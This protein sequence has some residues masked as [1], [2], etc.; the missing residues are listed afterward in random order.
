MTMKMMAN[1][2]RG[3]EVPGDEGRGHRPTFGERAAVPTHRAAH[4]NDA[5]SPMVLRP[6]RTVEIAVMRADS[7][8]PR[9]MMPE[10]GADS[11]FLLLPG[12]GE[13][14]ELMS[15][16]AMVFGRGGGGAEWKADALILRLPRSAAQIHASARHGGA[17]RLA[18]RPLS[19]DLIAGSPLRQM[20]AELVQG[21]A[22]EE[23]C[24][25]ILAEIVTALVA[26]HGADTAF[27]L[28]RSITFARAHL[29]KHATEPLALEELASKAGVTGITLQRGFK[30]CFGMTVASYS[31][32]VRLHGAR[33]RLQC[34]WESR[35]IAGIAHGA[36]FP[37]VTTFVRAYQKLFGE[38]PTQTRNAA[39][40]LNRIDHR[41]ST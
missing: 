31:Q 13:P 7:A 12:N 30:A 34:G 25:T 17:R 20:L 18:L 14:V 39:S 40:R 23:R 5:A 15:R 27:P 22:G 28:S 33:A 24:G 9:G 32:A 11:F 19:I 2:S 41:E 26:Q 4:A 16:R 38:T 1:M 35:S 36:A 37:S 6:P 10:G 21:D 8:N 29:D 3:H